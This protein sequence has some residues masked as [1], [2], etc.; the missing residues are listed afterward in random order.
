MLTL[1][2]KTAPAYRAALGGFTIDGPYC[3]RPAPSRFT[4]LA[5]RVLDWLGA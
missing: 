4:V 5:A 2:R 1:I 3:R